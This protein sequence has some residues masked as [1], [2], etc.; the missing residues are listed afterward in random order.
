MAEHERQAVA[1]EAHRHIGGQ[2]QGE[3]R[4]HP[5]D[6]IAAP[7]GVRRAAAPVGQR[8]RAHDDARVAA[9]WPDLADD[10]D[11]PI[12]APVVA[13]ARR[14]V[15][16]FQLATVAIAQHRAQH[17]GI[18]QVVLLAA[19]EIFQFHGEVAAF[20]LGRKQRAKGRVAVECRQATPHH[21]RL[22]IDQCTE[23]A[24]ADD[25]QIQVWLGHGVQTILLK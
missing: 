17:S 1:D 16:D 14:E 18:G 9:Q 25:A 2:A 12:E 20:G 5:T 15:D 23:T 10:A 21:A 8:A 22:T 11:R 13:P 7:G 3:F 24:V 4:Q 6:V 19:G